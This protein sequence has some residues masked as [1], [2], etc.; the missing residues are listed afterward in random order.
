MRRDDS[1]TEIGLCGDAVHTALPYYQNITP[2][3]FDKIMSNG[4]A[5]KAMAQRQCRPTTGRTSLSESGAPAS[6]KPSEAYHGYAETYNGR[7][8]GSCDREPFSA[9]LM[10]Q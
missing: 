9:K 2:V 10:W 6:G 8:A 4:K 3:I 1:S 7:R 5:M